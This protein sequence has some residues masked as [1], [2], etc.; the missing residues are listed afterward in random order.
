MNERGATKTDKSKAS[1]E[2]LK[3]FVALRYLNIYELNRFRKFV[4]SPY[5][6]VNDKITGIF[7]FWEPWLREE[8]EGFPDRGVSWQAATGKSEYNDVQFRKICSDLLRLYEQ[9]LVQES[10][11]QNGLHKADYLLEAVHE[12]R[13]E[14]LY[15][16]SVRT[17]QRLS[18]QYFL[19][20]ASHYYYQYSFERWIYNLQ[21]LE[22]ERSREINVEQIA[23]NLDLF[24]LAE[25]MRYYCYV[26]ARK[27]ITRHEYDLLFM[28]A[29]VKHIETEG[30][31][32]V[33]PINFYYQIYLTQTSPDEPEHYR[34]LKALINE[35]IYMLP[36]IEGKEIIDSALNYCIRRIN[37]GKSEFLKEIHEL[38][39]EALENELVFI[40]E[41]ITPWTFRNMVVSGLRLGEYAWVEKFIRDY[42]DRIDE[43]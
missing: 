33:V 19:R 13:L 18:D 41:K 38:Y 8:N 17:A 20:P 9:F 34:K 23:K 15:N 7:T 6:N 31:D 36:E 37:E 39:K 12:K 28:D 21:G 30:Y 35:K 11:S 22:I 5:F 26:L 29:I 24:Y 4:M 3:V 32:D 1:V 16:S 10:F 43:K 25:K 40:N 42:Q 2:D 14:P 27:P